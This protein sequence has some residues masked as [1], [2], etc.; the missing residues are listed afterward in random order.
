MPLHKVL[1]VGGGYA[2][3]LTATRLARKGRRR[4]AV[5]L[6]NDGPLFVERVRLPERAC[7]GREVSHDLASKLGAGIRFVVGRVASFAGDGDR[8]CAVLAGGEEEAFDTCVLATGSVF[9]DGGVPGVGVHTR[10]IASG[11]GAEAARQ[12]L[13]ELADGQRVMVCGGG[14]T[15][16]ELA[17]ELAESRPG[18]RIDL[19]CAG[20]IGPGLS[21]KGRAVVTRHLGERGVGLHPHTKVTG[22]DARGAAHAGGR[23]DAELVLWCGGFKPSPLARALGLAIDGAGRALVDD[24]LRSTSHPNVVVVGD[25]AAIVH[26]PLRMGCVTALPMAAHAADTILRG[27]AG[28]PAP[29]FRFRFV[30]QCISLGRRAGLVQAVHAD[31][32]PVERV[33]AGRSA[34]F[35]K[36]LICRYA[37]RRPFRDGLRFP[38]A[39]NEQLALAGAP[40]EELHV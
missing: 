12:G 15:A 17:A 24:C 28:Q 10:D 40:P 5:T 38:R 35:I 7:R 32:S 13:A 39:V 27:V 34:A 30:L 4:V 23:L 11:P 19:A 31:D 16:I 2:G 9:A 3:V 6:I 20:D 29:P 8:S 37:A 18:L 21:I 33:I 22:V 1:V 25:S 14:L 26:N 36:E